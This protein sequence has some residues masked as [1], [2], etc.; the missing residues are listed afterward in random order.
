[1][2]CSFRRWTLNVERLTFG[3]E[4]DYRVTADCRLLL[5]DLPETG[6][7]AYLPANHRAETVRSGGDCAE[8][9]A[10]RALPI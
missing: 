5:R 2:V 1:M 4:H 6:D 8:T 10:N 7:V 9:R 3:I